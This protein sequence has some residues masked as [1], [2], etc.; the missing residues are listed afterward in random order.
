[1]RLNSLYALAATAALV[2][3]LSAQTIIKDNLPRIAAKSYSDILY[4]AAKIV[5]V[6][7]NVTGLTD[8]EAAKLVRKRPKSV[9]EFDALLQKHAKESAF[10]APIRAGRELGEMESAAETKT[11]IKWVLTAD[12]NETMR[13]TNAEATRV[14]NNAVNLAF[15]VT[16]NPTTEINN[17]IR[18]TG[19]ELVKVWIH[20]S[21][22][23]PRE[24]HRDVLHG[25]L[26]DRDGYW[27]QGDDK[28]D[29]PG[30]FT[31]PGNNIGCRCSIEVMTVQEYLS[32][33]GRGSLQPWSYLPSAGI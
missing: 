9:P 13:F 28:A 15:A 33:F 17:L 20:D 19:L 31:E 4:Q 24:Y 22:A 16:Q 1:M 25:S 12:A 2:S 32:R 11:A 14:I 21:P 23:V 7:V 5:G 18:S 29:G 3:P 10:K 26:P 6:E 27:H 30:G 8:A